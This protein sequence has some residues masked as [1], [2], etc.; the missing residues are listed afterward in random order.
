MKYFD[1]HCHLQMPQFDADRAAVL[2]RMKESD[3]GGVVIGTDLELSRAAVALAAQHDFLWAAVGLHPNDNIHEA[4]D[5]A[6]YTGLATHP[7]VAAIGECGLDYFR[8]DEAPTPEEGRGPDQSV[9]KK[10]AQKARFEAQIE[11]ALTAGK[12]LIVHCRDSQQRIANI[13]SAHEDMLEI[14][15]NYM[16]NHP[17]LKVII[18]FFTGTGELAQKYLS[19]GCYLSFPGPITY[20]D[21]YDDSIRIAPLDKILSET[22]S[23]FA[24]PVPHRGKRNE[25][26]YVS[27]VV[28]KIALIKGVDLDT[29]AA[30]ILQNSQKVFGIPTL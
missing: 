1:A 6:A 18:H 8:L 20:T 5:A 26:A 16:G 9:G 28:K 7:K 2:A 21:M 27:H 29:M 10:A 12:P 13:N 23:P 15:K 11:L 3:M 24:A 4:F 30:Q 25:P 14:L 19:L 17:Q 22:D